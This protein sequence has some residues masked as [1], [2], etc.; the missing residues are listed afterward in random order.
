[1]PNFKVITRT[2]ER[3]ITAV[4]ARNHL[5]LFGDASDDTEIDEFILS[6]QQYLDDYLGEFIGTTAVQVPVRSFGNRL[7]GAARQR[8]LPFD[9][10]F[11][12]TIELPH[13]FIKSLTSLRYYN[14]QDVL[15]TVAPT[16]YLYDDSGVDPVISL[17]T[18]QSW[19]ADVSEDREFP[20]I[21]D[22]SAG[23]STTVSATVGNVDPAIRSAVLLILD[24]LY[25]N[26]ASFIVNGT[27]TQLPI[28]AERLLR[29]YRR[30][31]V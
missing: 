8:D 3:V 20:V 17:R 30:V 7:V 18:G 13:R 10:R 28:T 16:V 19:P 21:V 15:T 31:N 29:G 5:R 14:T 25:H 12:N 11:S 26:R 23:L 1:M 22:Y 2:T 27:I 9:T 24:E 4:E 6:A